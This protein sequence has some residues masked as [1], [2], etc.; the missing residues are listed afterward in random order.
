M[1]IIGYFQFFAEPYVMTQGGPVNSTL[2]VVFYLYQQG[3][4]WWRMGYA[5]SIAFM[6]FFI[7]FLIAMIQMAARKR[8]E[9]A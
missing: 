2:S 1:T 6:L 4:R 9:A 7:I 8:Q 5:S 3:F